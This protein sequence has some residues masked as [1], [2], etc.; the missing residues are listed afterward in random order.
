MVD[1]T[2]ATMVDE[3]DEDDIREE[4]LQ[5]VQEH[6]DILINLDN[7]DDVGRPAGAMVPPI[8]PPLPDDLPLG[9][10]WDNTIPS[11]LADHPVIAA[12]QASNANFLI[13]NPRIAG[14][15]I[16]YASEVNTTRI[17]IHNLTIIMQNC[18]KLQCST[19]RRSSS[20]LLCSFL[21]AFLKTQGF[22]EMTGYPVARV[23]G[24]NC[25]FLQGPET[26]PVAVSQMRDAI[27]RGEDVHVR[28]LNYRNNGTTFHNDVM[29]S[30]IRDPE[31]DQILYF[32]GLQCCIVDDEPGLLSTE[33]LPTSG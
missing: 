19:V 18:H 15:P 23:L 21:F 7:H 8:A 13:S 22:L 28:V 1:W 16:I 17:K 24:R 29:I 27:D 9:E 26:D 2:G 5:M 10:E 31:T 30:A 25:R 32:V 12:F 11:D 33:S 3:G 4:I 6:G 14:N 20:C